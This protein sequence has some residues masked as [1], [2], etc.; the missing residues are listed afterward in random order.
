MARSPSSSSD[1]QKVS[2]LAL[3]A[4]SCWI[5]RTGPRLIACSL[6]CSD[7][8]RPIFWGRQT[9]RARPQ[10][11]RDSPLIIARLAVNRCSNH[12]PSRAAP[13]GTTGCMQFCL[14][15]SCLTFSLVRL[16]VDPPQPALA[17]LVSPRLDPPGGLDTCVNCITPSSSLLSP[18][19]NRSRQSPP[20]FVFLTYFPPHPLCYCVR[21]WIFKLLPRL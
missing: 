7:R 20:S 13:P 17:C 9:V 18:A 5:P 15:G 6:A 10:T 14:Q 4:P 16:L 8:S 21:P 19:S 12:R 2:L 3:G 11:S 1:S